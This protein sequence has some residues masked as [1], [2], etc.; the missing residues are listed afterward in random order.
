MDERWEG[1]VAGV[2]EAGRGPLAGPV[3]AAAVILGP[4]PIE[5]LADSK[6]LAP[7]AR[8]R[9]AERIRSEALAWRLGYAWECEIDR[10]NILQA[11][12]RAMA[13][14]VAG[15]S[16][17]IDRVLVD[18]SH[19]IPGLGHAQC[20]VVR[21]DATVPAISAASILA[22]TARDAILG[23]CD[24]LYPEYGFGLHKGYGTERHLSAL[25]CYGPCPIHRRSFAPVRALLDASEDAEA[26]V[27]ALLQPRT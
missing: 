25:A 12:F 8:E 1:I 21:G 18:G 10:V 19:T 20:A 2:D 16:L 23:E 5:G 22:K 14:A 24:L 3:V 6:K 17:P 11:T 15:I 26:M 13:R 4:E 9:L 27:L 7:A